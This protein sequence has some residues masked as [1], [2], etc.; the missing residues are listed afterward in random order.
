M[1]VVKNLFFFYTYPKN[2]VLKEYAPLE[3][4]KN[5]LLLLIF[6]WCMLIFFGVIINTLL[7]EFGI[8]KDP[9]AKEKLFPSLKTALLLAGFV[10][11]IMEEFVGRIWLIYSKLNLSIALAA[12]TSAIVFKFWLKNDSSESISYG[13]NILISSGIGIAVFFLA[14]LTFKFTNWNLSS[15]FQKNTRLLAIASGI[16]FGYLH[17]FNYRISTNLM[18]FSPIFLANFIIGGFILGFIRIR[19]GFF[20]CILFHIVYNS[21][22]I[23]IKY[24]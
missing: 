16:F 10:V 8:F 2:E 18:I 5:T 21:I 24:R 15:F 14:Q 17:L 6:N 3:K 12:I 23:I 13:L 20:Y 1:N 7:I 4:I 11:P 9:I 22:F 19:Y